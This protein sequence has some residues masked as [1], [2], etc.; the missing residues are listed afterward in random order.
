VYVAA[1]A[2]PRRSGTHARPADRRG[3]RNT[4][5]LAAARA[6][7]DPAWPHVGGDPLD[8]DLCRVTPR[9]PVRR[10]RLMQRFLDSLQRFLERIVGRNDLVLATLIVCI[11][12]MM[13]LPLPTW[14]IDALI[15]VNMCV[16]AILL[17]VAMYLPS[18]LAFSS[19]PS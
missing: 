9:R 16:S 13:I 5:V 1:S 12:F 14:L 8:A 15:A 2:S 6:G 4:A 10:R 19:F 11:I 7:A 17:M 18:P 3:A